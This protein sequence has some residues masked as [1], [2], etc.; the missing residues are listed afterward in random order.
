MYICS[1]KNTA[2]IKGWQLLQG[3]Y[4]HVTL[5][6]NTATVAVDDDDDGDGDYDDDDDDM[7]TSQ[8]HRSFTVI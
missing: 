3:I 1:V 2:L 6:I 8:S 4:L 7:L 5:L